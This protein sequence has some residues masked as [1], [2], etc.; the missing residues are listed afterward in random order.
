MELTAL[1]PLDGR[2]AGRL[3]PL[4]SLFSEAGLIRH[5]LEIEIAWFRHLAAQPDFTPLPALHP[6]DDAFIQKLLADFSIE[7]AEAIK[8]I[9]RTTNHDVKAVEYWLKARLGE[10][11]RLVEHLEMVHFACT[12]E[13]INNLSYSRMLQQ[14]LVDVL[15]PVLAEL[16]QRLSDMALE[17]ADLAMLS[18]T[19][20]Q[21]ASPT[22]LGKEIA[23][24]VFRL[25]R[26]RR[27][28]R[29]VEISGKINGAVGNFNAHIAACPEIDWPAVARD[30][31]E[32]LG[33]VWNPYTTQIEPHD[34]I[35]EAAHALMRIN[36]VLL[37]FSRDTWAYISL[38]YYSQKTVEGEVGSST[39]PHKVNP[40]D[41]ENGEGNLGLANSL[42]AH[43]A[44][45]LPVSRWQRDLTDS[46]VQRSLGS[47]MGYCLLA[48]RS[49]QR[50]LGRIEPD[51]PRIGAD[52]DGA[53]EV[54]AEAIQTVMRV[55]RIEQ[56]Y[57]K[58]KTLTRGRKINADDV[59]K[60]IETLD[61]PASER[62]R[63]LEMT[64][65]GYT[66]NAEAMAR[67]IERFV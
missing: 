14:A 60:F 21:S 49:I 10:R 52:I 46:T 1:S 26:Q 15:D 13:D 2:Y 61:L 16:D 30:F 37:D 31:V 29:R 12:S 66:G 3:E 9:E 39:M 59:R 43:L 32:D 18:R 47:A 40:I 56:P 67:A 64:P 48:W 22:T 53:W 38:G 55:H 7:D 62:R 6:E 58:L 44:D 5:R 54:L 57:E 20:G 19:H 8:Q 41:F 17:H 50:G 51:R 65:A 11:E 35:A 23:N 34:M 4:R 27:Q 45:K 25:R 63:L 24:V 42:L 36:T 28:L 33:L